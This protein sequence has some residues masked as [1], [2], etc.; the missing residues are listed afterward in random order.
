MLVPFSILL[1]LLLLLPAP[2]L[3][4]DLPEPLLVLLPQE[5]HLPL[6]A[7]DGGL[8]DIGLRVLVGG[9]AGRLALAVGVGLG[10]LGGVRAG[11]GAVDGAAVG[12]GRLVL[13]LGVDLVDDLGAVLGG[14]GEE[15][16]P[17][18]PAVDVD[19]PDPVCVGNRH[20]EV[21]QLADVRLRR[22]A[23][24]VV[25]SKGHVLEA[26][27][28]AEDH[29]GAEEDGV[30][31]VEEEFAV[32]VVEAHGEPQVLGEELHEVLPPLLLERLY[33]RPPDVAQRVP[34]PHDVHAGVLHVDEEVVRRRD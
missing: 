1:L 21:P 14:L 29:V 11:V 13:L 16:G 30:L 20:G 23:L 18:V 6:G 2:V 8:H 31:V 3:P 27:V 12:V 9:E 28:E 15:L 7:L 26:Q 32:P 4:G 10:T 34:R 24:E 19:R 17:V 22:H 5:V 33:G 25:R